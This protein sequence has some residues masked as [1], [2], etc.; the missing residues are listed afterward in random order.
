LGREFVTT[1][2]AIL[3]SE[4]TPGGPS[5]NA[6]ETG[7]TAI[8]T[9]SA[10]SGPCGQKACAPGFQSRLMSALSSLSEARPL[11]YTCSNEASE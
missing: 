5:Q 9:I 4:I 11:S 7:S 2:Q 8:T 6:A 10:A 1:A 3:A